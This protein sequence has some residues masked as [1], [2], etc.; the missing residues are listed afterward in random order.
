M[1]N[2]ISIVP[3]SAPFDAEQR[4]W[5][6]GFLSG[7]LG[8]QGVDG[9][10]LAGPNGVMPS[11][12]GSNGTEPVEEEEEDHPWHDPALSMDER[13]AMAEDKPVKHKLMAA[14][15]QLDCGSCGYV[16]DTYAAAIASGEEKSL[17]LCVPGAKETSKK[18]KELVKLNPIGEAAPATSSES[19]P[20]AAKWSRQNPFQAKLKRGFNLNKPG[21]AKQT[22]HV[23]ID[24]SGSDLEYVVGDSLGVFPTNC[25]QLVDDLIAA[26]GAS[27][28]EPVTTAAGVNS[29]LHQALLHHCCLTSVTEEL[30]EL[31]AKTSAD[32]AEVQNL[33]ALI[34]DDSPLDGMDILDLVRAHPK[35]RPMPTDFIKVLEP[36]AP[37][38]YSISSSL[39]KAPNEV[40]LTVGRVSWQSGE[41]ERKGVASTMF[42]DRL[43][44]GGA[45]SVYIQKSHGFTVPADPNAP[46]IMV[47]PGTGIAPFRAFLQ[48]REAAGATG[49]NWLFFGDQRSSTD[50]LYEE[51]FKAYQEAGLLSRV[52]LAFSRDQQ[53]K[54]Y[55]QNRM[56]E[57][58]AEFWSWLDQGAHFFVCG[59]AKR[60]ASDVDKALH[61]IV[62]EQGGMSEADAKE[63]VKQLAKS[64]RYGRDV[65]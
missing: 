33:K 49:K 14:M 64:G 41:R 25:D 2:L 55:V 18:L 59:D 56:L 24:L 50:F 48:E 37:R 15:A 44:E 6:N 52:D 63:Y 8:V 34:E 40:H 13:M 31:L 9:T 12:N 36:L 46:M 45:V 60:M 7:W 62:S 17:T 20:A 38:L 10:P 42:A 11:S 39:K 47:G 32:E 3:E 61:Q 30:L 58:A 4:A 53:E 27:R 23:E 29:S 5:L 51:E 22:T 21:S 28:D 57:N 35:S 16:C 43:P 54:V 19:A 65:Y 1:S 26:I